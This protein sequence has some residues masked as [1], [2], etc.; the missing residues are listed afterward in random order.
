MPK[1][2]NID[3]AKNR[4]R[5][6]SVC[7]RPT[8]FGEWSILREWGRIGSPGTV[9]VESY[10]SEDEAHAAERITIR[11]RTRHGYHEANS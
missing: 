9:R 2:I 11:T 4:H 5:F 8:L 7:I 1:L 3:A 6:Y 10:S